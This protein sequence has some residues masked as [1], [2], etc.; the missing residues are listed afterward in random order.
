MFLKKQII[1]KTDN[2]EN[3]KRGCDRKI[4]GI[5]YNINQINVNLSK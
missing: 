1:K 4:S 3:R 2:K 5:D